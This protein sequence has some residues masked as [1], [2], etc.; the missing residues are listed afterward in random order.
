LTRYAACA[1]LRRVVVEYEGK[2]YVL[3]RSMRVKDLL[4]HLSLNRE[5]V[6]V[7]VDGVLVTEDKTVR[8]G[9]K[10]KII[11]VVSGG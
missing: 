9:E 11:R 1:N 2:V 5:A 4:A 6:I 10:V 8:E 3:D 7:V